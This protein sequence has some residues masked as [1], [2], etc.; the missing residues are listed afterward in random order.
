MQHYCMVTLSL[1]EWNHMAVYGLLHSQLNSGLKVAA[2]KFLAYR[3]LH[4]VKVLFHAWE[5]TM[6]VMIS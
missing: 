3:L 2:R 6:T 5:N 4:R 1:V